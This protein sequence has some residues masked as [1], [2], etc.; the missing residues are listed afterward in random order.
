MIRLLFTLLFSVS[1]LSLFGQ[2]QF[3]ERPLDPE[4]LSLG[5]DVI[6]T[7]ADEYL[8]SNLFFPGGSAI[9]NAGQLNLTRLTPSGD[10]VWS[11]DLVFPDPLRDGALANWK[12][13]SAYLFGG[14]YFESDVLP[15]AVLSRLN[16][17]GTLLWSKSF[18]L[19]SSI[20]WANEARVD[21][22]ALEDG[23]ALLGAGPR[24]HF[25]DENTND[26]SLLKVDPFGDL[27]WGK[28]YCISCQSDADLTFGNVVATPDSGFVVCG[29]IQYIDSLGVDKDVFLMKVDSV[30]E[31]LWSK[32]YNITDSLSLLSQSTGFAAAIL[33]NGNIAIVGESERTDITDNIVDG[34]ILQTDSAGVVLNGLL[35][36][37]EIPFS[38]LYLRHLAGIDSST[39]VIP[40][41]S[42]LDSFPVIENNF[43]F[44]IQL[45]DGGID[46]QTQFVQESNPGFQTFSSGFSPLP[47]GY[48][49]LPNYSEGLN[50]HY[51][52]L[53]VADQTGR[54]GCHD[55]I[56]LVVNPVLATETTDLTPVLDS[57]AEGS[58]YTPTLTPFEEYTMDV[59]VLSLGN[60]E[61]FCDPTTLPLD[62]T[63]EGAESYLWNTGAITP[64]ILAEVPG[65]YFVE[66]TSNL[67][68][69]ILR[70]TISFNILPPPQVG[71]AADTT[72]FCDTGEATLI[73]NV[74]GAT[75]VFWS[76]GETSNTITV[77]EA[78]EY[79]IQA[80]NMCGTTIQS[81]T[82]VVP[83]CTGDP[84]DCR[85]EIPNAFTPDN[86]GINDEFR[87]LSNCEVYE[88]YY[89]RIY[90]RWGQLIF[91]ST[92]P[93][94]GWNG[95]YKSKNM[96][97]DLYGWILEYKFP[98]D[99]EVRLEK[100]EVTLLR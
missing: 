64:Q 88:E 82:L 47:S 20:Y 51:P 54:T 26:L 78:G 31:V 92:N 59:P 98:N 91:E 12:D 16:Q 99:E 29:G 66:D 35:V 18:A 85:V 34:L 21:V 49:L 71:V 9:L 65:T 57:L 70:D 72:G 48:A 52:Y 45:N 97:S 44:Q 30:G 87:P 50:E 7:G 96:V 86:D 25:S 1:F 55:T 2:S 46:W 17:D 83:N 36:N 56:D 3:F 11:N 76:T 62:A 5:N 53:I 39:V 63:V 23:N 22:L 90:S 74:I 38:N 69:W 79:T 33:P 75:S 15:F 61:F 8:F 80:E 89:L 100:G 77:T 40:G 41:H 37:L 95:R 32:S 68:C 93:N 73:A 10:I 43:L 60:S 67:Q 84:E 19:D 14:F 27:L 58:D 42:V 4:R 81:F 24:N 6:P 13:Q 94:T 28:N